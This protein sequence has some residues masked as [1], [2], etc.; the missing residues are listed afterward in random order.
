MAADWM[1]HFDASQLELIGSSQEC[2]SD[3]GIPLSLPGRLMLI[4]AKMADLLS[5]GSGDPAGAGVADGPA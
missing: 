5:A 2:A 4:V 3:D 1:D